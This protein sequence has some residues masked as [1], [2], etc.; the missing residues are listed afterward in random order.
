MQ[1]IQDPYSWQPNTNI[2]RVTAMDMDGE[3]SEGKRIEGKGEDKWRV[4]KREWTGLEER[5][6]EER[7]GGQKGEGREKDRGEG[8]GK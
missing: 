8:G 2:A 3:E 4:M 5:E 7:D 6:E 1:Q